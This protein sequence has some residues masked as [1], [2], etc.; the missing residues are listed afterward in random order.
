LSLHASKSATN[1][2]QPRRQRCGGCNGVNA[3]A[4]CCVTH[5]K[6]NYELTEQKPKRCGGNGATTRAACFVTPCTCFKHTCPSTMR[7]RDEPPPVPD[8]AWHTPPPTQVISS[9]PPPPCHESAH[10]SLP[11]ANNEAVAA[12]VD[13]AGAG[14]VGGGSGWRGEHAGEGTRRRGLYR[15]AHTCHAAMSLRRG[16]Y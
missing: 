5:F 2:T 7:E 16:F 9:T 11:G 10:R 12:G 8:S 3:R 4:A 13:E 15:R 1:R 6:L 14:G